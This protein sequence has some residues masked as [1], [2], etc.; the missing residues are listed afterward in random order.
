VEEIRESNNI[1]MKVLS[2]KGEDGYFVSNLRLNM[3]Q[4]SL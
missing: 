2:R 3:R 4:K 1:Y